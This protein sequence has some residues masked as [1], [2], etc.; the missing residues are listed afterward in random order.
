MPFITHEVFY[1]LMPAQMQ[2]AINIYI[3]IHAEVGGTLLV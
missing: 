1:S 3:D 2:I